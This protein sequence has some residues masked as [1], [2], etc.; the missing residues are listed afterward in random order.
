M[1]PENESTA[2]VALRFSVL[3]P[4]R[5]WRHATE[6]SLGP[7]KQRLLLALLLVRSDRP[8]PLHQIV[9]ALWDEDPPEHAVNVVHRHI[10]ALRRLLEPE[11]TGRTG[12]RVLVRAAGG[13][14]LNTEDEALDLLRF[15][16]LRDAAQ[17]ASAAGRPAEATG[18]F[19]RALSL[20]LGR[21]AEGLPRTA[22][23]HAVFAGIDA[24]YPHTA[25]DAADAALAAGDTSRVLPLVRRAAE[26][27]P[28]NECLQA[29]LVLVLA[30]EGLAAQALDHYQVVRSR[31]TSELGVD[32]GSELREAQIR[33]LRGTVV[34]T[35]TSRSGDPKAADTSGASS[36]GGSRGASPGAGPGAT[37]R[38]RPAQLPADLHAFTGRRAELDWMRDLLPAD[39]G[40]PATVVISAI[41]GAPGVGKT[42][43]ALHWAHSNTRH[44]PDGQ[45]Y[46]NLRGYDPAGVALTPSAAICYFLEALGVP[47]EDIPPSLD[48]Q[49]ALYRSMLAG[50][51][52]LVVLDNARSAEQ[53]RPLLPG[54]PT[55]VTVITSREQLYGLVAAN[56]ARSLRLDILTV[57]ES[58]EFMTKRLGAARVTADR[59]AAV[60]IAEQCGRLPLALAIV[61]ARAEGHPSAPLADIAAELAESRDDLGVF[62]VGDPATDTRAVFS[63][64]YRTLTPAAAGLFRLLWLCPPHDVSA[65]AVASLAGLTTAQTRPVLSELTRASLWAEPAPGLYGSHELLRTFSQELSLAEDPPEAR[66]DARRRL[67]DHY[68]HSARGAATQL[69]THREPLPLPDAAPGTQVLSFSDTDSA[70]KWLVREMPALEAVITRDS[71]HGTGAHAW[72]MAATL[73]LVLDRRG[74]R[75]EQ[76]EL[77]TTALAGAQRLGE[78]LGEAHMHRV[79]GFAHVRTND[80]AR[81]AAH[82]ERALELFTDLGDVPFTA[83]THRYLA[84]LANV[85][86]DHREA[87]A[88]YKIACALYTRTRAYVGIASVTNEVAWTRLLLHEYEEALGD[89]RR[90][91]RI[92]HRSGN[93]NIKAAAWDTM[94]VAHHRLGQH[95]EALEAFD[96]ALT[97][98][99]A[100]NDASLIADTLVHRGEA[101]AV[102]SPQE[103]RRAWN[104]ALAILDVLGHTDADRLRELLEEHDE[105]PSRSGPVTINI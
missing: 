55:C 2:D 38:V 86:Q 52:V 45:L 47:A 75:E 102:T 7:P 93:R 27:E 97:H 68:L 22:Y 6:L 98:Y 73:E 67:F 28:L 81:G 46:V 94:G 25:R 65:Q 69:Y 29:R 17:T 57:T 77:H 13:Y 51:R 12:A 3:G 96:H 70:A 60:R 91:V 95:D 48:G 74:R 33:V 85:R 54:T 39:G 36:P 34:P 4:L 84:F 14:R 82:L 20:W 87:L 58:I 24:E 88:Q 101:L 50:R 31:L 99:R 9:D 30:A 15:R 78:T 40:T 1:S 23:S 8:V 104:E 103:A 66:E 44:F 18:L 63:W 49:A 53:V 79:L 10:G 11:L 35:R 105:V 92:A 59:Q 19:V 83:L 89:C 90:A 21:T 64:S 80:H 61:C 100:L 41:G 76:I 43:L 16:R 32:P 42:T 37:P 72:R 26:S 56:G 62:A 5:A 71:G